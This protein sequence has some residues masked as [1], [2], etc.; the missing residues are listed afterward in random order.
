MDKENTGVKIFKSEK[1]EI[2]KAEVNKAE[3]N[4]TE[5]DKNEINKAKINKTE[6]KKNEINKA[7]INKTETKKNEIKKADSKKTGIIRITTAFAILIILHIALIFISV[8]AGSIDTGFIKLFRG[9]FVEYDPDIAIIYDLRFPRIIVSMTAGAALATAGTL[10]QAVLKNPLADPGIIGVTSGAGFAG[11]IVSSFFPAIYYQKPLFCVVGACVA[12]VMVYMLSWQ[13]GLTPIRIILIGIAVEAVF[14][15]F[16]QGFEAMAG[17]TLSG[18]A[19]ITDGNVTLKTWTDVK[20]I[21]AYAVPG[22]IIALLTFSICNI[23]ILKD[24]TVRGLGINVN[25][26][27]IIVSFIAVFLAGVAT[28]FAG[29]I[30]FL[31]LIVPHIGRLI[32]GNN[33]KVLIPYS[34][35]L[36]SFVFLLADTLGRTIAMPY[37]ISPGIIMAVIGGPSFIMLLRKEKNYGR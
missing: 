27:R 26:I 21:I 14:S 9:L 29:A 2:N 36:G 18:V 8:L 37:E 35:I 32:V 16:T 19:S 22:L 5:A 4:K 31:G 13:N 7:E 17:S 28:A 6:A 23:L 11:V 3:I 33:H 12:F 10:L 1:A 30:S 15:G 25:R 24:E 20:T 34:M